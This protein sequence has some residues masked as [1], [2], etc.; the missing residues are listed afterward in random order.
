MLLAQRVEPGCELGGGG[1]GN[2]GTGRA[3]AA[4]RE[5]ADDEEPPESGA[6]DGE[7]LGVK[8]KKE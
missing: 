8:V 7:K 3:A 4:S 1:R 5:K 2:D 6:M